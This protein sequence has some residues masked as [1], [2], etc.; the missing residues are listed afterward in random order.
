MK[1]P[2]EK[3][4][5]IVVDDSAYNRRALKEMLESEPT[6]TVV[7]TAVNGED[8]VKK[9][10]TLKPDI[11]TLDLEMPKMDGFTFLRI[12]MENFPTPTIVISS[13]DEDKSVFK[14]LELGA[15]DF[16]AKP[17]EHISRD[18]HKVREELLYKVASALSFNTDALRA[19]DGG[20]AAA[21]TVLPSVRR[22]S[23]GGMEDIPI[24]VIGA[25]TGGPTSLLSV[26]SKIP[27]DIPASIAIAQHMPAG[28]TRSFAERLDKSSTLYVKEAEEG[29]RLAA[30]KVLV[31]PGGYHMTVTRRGGFPLVT[32]SDGVTSK[33]VPSVD[34]LF[35][36]A[37][38]IFGEK[39]LGVI[40]TGMGS[41]GKEGIVSIK[42]KGGK[43]I[44]QSMKTSVIPGMTGEA[45]RTGKVD[46]ILDLESLASGILDVSATI[47]SYKNKAG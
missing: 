39:T 30:G 15:A 8:A 25:S 7:A 9:V 23:H 31:A 20:E 45:I 37:A 6:V 33:Y 5:A 16:I 44:S 32:L 14:A 36:S 18:I 10:A 26:L 29:E 38:D 12:M 3:I 17:T 40:M 47:A 42:A 24:V 34:D 22:P 43:T 11:I 21:A 19:H 13:R 1:V 28:F 35:N 4:R 2:G 27:A 41:D 46:R